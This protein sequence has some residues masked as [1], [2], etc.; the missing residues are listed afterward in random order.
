[1]ENQAT[2]FYIKSSGIQILQ[3][4]HFH[5]EKKKMLISLANW[6]GNLPLPEYF[7]WGR[8]LNPVVCF[9]QFFKSVIS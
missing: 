7:H 6:T 2:V 9:Q 4:T 3:L 8:E 1:M 5:E